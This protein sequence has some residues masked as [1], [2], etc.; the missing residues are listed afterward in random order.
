RESLATFVSASAARLP[1]SSGADF[2]IDRF[3][4]EHGFTVIRD[5]P[6]Q[7]QKGG[8][9]LELAVCPFNADHIGGSA[10]FTFTNGVPG[11]SC[12]HNGCGG[13]TISDLLAKY[14]VKP[15]LNPG[16]NDGWPPLAPFQQISP[17]PIS[18]HGFPGWLGEMANAVAAN[19]ETPVEL[20]A[21]LA[22]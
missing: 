7:S 11:L 1:S 9:I 8:R 21:L 4:E 17:E 20:A 14:S 22:T 5:K 18:A 10:A 19:T 6:W 12:K 15:S 16:V 13:K 3:I 2:D